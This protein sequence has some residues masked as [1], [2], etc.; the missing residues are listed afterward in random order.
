M[1]ADQINVLASSV[2]RDLEQIDETQESRFAGQRWSNIGKPDRL[3]RIYLDLAL[4][5]AVARADSNVGTCPESNARSD[6]SATNSLAKPLGE[7]H[8]R[9]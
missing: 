7:G 4:L 8:D 5:H 3:N 2:L 9:R 6:F 1:E